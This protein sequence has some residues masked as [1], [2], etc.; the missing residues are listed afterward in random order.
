MF[1]LVPAYPGCPGSKA[2][3]QSLLLLLLLSRQLNR[4][5][6]RGLLTLSSMTSVERSTTDKLFH[7]TDPVTANARHHTLS[8]CVEQTAGS[9]WLITEVD[10]LSSICSIFRHIFFSQFIETHQDKNDCSK[11]YPLPGSIFLISV[12]MLVA[13]DQ[14]HQQRVGYSNLVDC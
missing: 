14:L 2:V 7:V 12:I 8:L 3:K 4:N 9:C 1:L 5:V 6:L 13:V 11:A 10:G